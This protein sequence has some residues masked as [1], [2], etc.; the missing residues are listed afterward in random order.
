MAKKNAKNYG[1]TARRAF[2]LKPYHGNPAAP[3]PKTSKGDFSKYMN[4]GRK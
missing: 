3:K 4:R 2:A 1:K